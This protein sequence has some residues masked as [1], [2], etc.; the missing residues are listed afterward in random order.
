MTGEKRL[1]TAGKLVVTGFV[2]FWIFVATAL[3]LDYEK[4][5]LRFEAV[6][7]AA[8]AAER[9]WGTLDE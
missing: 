1:N 4:A 6:Q 3:W 8:Q 2:L 9:I 7:Q 5:V